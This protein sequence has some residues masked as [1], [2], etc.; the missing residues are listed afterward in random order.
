MKEIL[1]TTLLEYGKSAFLIEIVRNATGAKY[2]EITQTITTDPPEI[3]KIKINRVLLADILV[4]L[5]EYH[6]E[7]EEASKIT[8]TY[9]TA[10]DQQKI[11]DR[12]LK[13]I[14]IKDLALQFGK[15]EALIERVLRNRGIEI[16]S[17]KIPYKKRWKRRK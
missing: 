14:P 12:Y 11:Q 6:L 15:S 2:V 10:S 9:L 8:P 17:N 5:L 1:Q 16:V 3:Q 4:T 13:G 7:I